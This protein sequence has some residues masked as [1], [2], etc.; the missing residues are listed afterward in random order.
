VSSARADWRAISLNRPISRER[1]SK[2]PGEI[3]YG[4][5]D[6]GDMWV[7]LAQR[8]AIAALLHRPCFRAFAI[9]VGHK[10]MG[11]GARV[12]RQLGALVEVVARRLRNC[13]ETGTRGSDPHGYRTKPSLGRRQVSRPKARKRLRGANCGARACSCLSDG[14]LIAACHSRPVRLSG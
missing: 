1:A 11:A 4:H 13:A 5:G 3:E 12:Q 14:S 9:R 8:Y 7:T 2:R 10:H 6:S